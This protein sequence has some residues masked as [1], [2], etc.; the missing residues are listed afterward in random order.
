LDIKNL[1]DLFPGMP[2]QSSLIWVR[3]GAYPRVDPLVFNFG[4]LQPNLQ[5]LV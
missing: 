3:S 4:K 5:V 1:I 2:F